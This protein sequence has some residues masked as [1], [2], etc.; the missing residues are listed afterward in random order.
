MQTKKVN[1]GHLLR[2]VK[3]EKIIETIAKFCEEN[4]IHGGVISGLGG[5]SC[6]TL[7]FYDLG[8]K[9][10]TWKEFAEVHEI[11]S[12]NGNVALVDGKP[13]LHIHIALSNHNFEAIGGHLKEAT[14]GATCE[15]MISDLATEMI[16]IYD[17]QIGLKLLDL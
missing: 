8:T 5:A 13:F 12:M 16:R 10:Y 6:I 17:D 11:L 14:V 3:G 15:V 7:G 9:E 4:S 1:G 2:L